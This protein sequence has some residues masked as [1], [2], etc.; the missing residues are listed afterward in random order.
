MLYLEKLHIRSFT[1]DALKKIFPL[2]FKYTKDVPNL[3]I[4]IILQILAIAVMAVLIWLATAIVGWIPVI[5]AIIGWAL[6][7][8]SSLLG[9][10]CLVGIIIQ[11]L[12]F[13]KV[14]K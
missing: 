9:L 6:G 13:A 4:G 10:Y 12:V 5:G 11:I 7:I 2:S 14:I 8:V 3:I 1:M